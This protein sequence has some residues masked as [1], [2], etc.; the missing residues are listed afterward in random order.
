MPER[1][2][3]IRTILLALDASADSLAG[4][5]GVAQLASELGAEITGLFVEE[6]D[7]I[8]AGR[9]PDVREIPFFSPE[10]RR[11]EAQTLER[12]LRSQA[13]RAQEALR[14]VAERLRVTWSFHTSR[15]DV[16]EELLE[17]AAEADLVALGATG[18]SLS[19]PPGSTVRRLVREARRPVLVYR[20]GARLGR[21]IHVLHDG[22]EAGWE[23]VRTAAE[24]GRWEGG[25]LN[26]LL[27]PG[28]AEEAE[29]LEAETD[30]L[31]REAG[32]PA[33]FRHLAG[34]DTGRI[35]SALT[36]GGGV[37]VAPGPRFG[38]RREELGRLLRSAGCPVVL[39]NIPPPPDPGASPRARPDATDR[40]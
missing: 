10:P 13:K 25:R 37:L 35:C 18:R 16:A 27:A 11:L 29:A 32:L 15:G 40:C 3:P 12:Q 6:A 39:V 14:S 33:R 5:E 7:L 28:D 21:A 1:R 24:L 30:R 36:D 22:S 26:V 38:D 20:Q 19:R 8:R 23:A 17:A 9:L 2:R 4:L 31:L 34:D